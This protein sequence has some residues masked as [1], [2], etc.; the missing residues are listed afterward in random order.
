MTRANWTT[1]CYLFLVPYR[2]Q[3]QI[4][5][6]RATTEEGRD[7]HDKGKLDD[8]GA[9]KRHYN[10]ERATEDHGGNLT[11][12]PDVPALEGAGKLVRA[13]QSERGGKDNAADQYQRTCVRR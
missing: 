10:Q 5:G 13:V 1:A 6:C 8:R 3:K 11:V 4:A 2:D 7:A 12:R 9:A